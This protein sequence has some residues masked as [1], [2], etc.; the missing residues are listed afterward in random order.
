[1]H[2]EPVCERG[3]TLLAFQ[4]VPARQVRFEGLQLANE[5]QHLFAGRG[6]PLGFEEFAPHIYRGRVREDANGAHGRQRPSLP[7]R[8]S[9]PQRGLRFLVRPRTLTAEDAVLL[10]RRLPSGRCPCVVV[11]DNVSIHVA[12]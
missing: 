8:P 12:R 11:L 2:G 10:L 5:V 6:K 9:G 4:R 1:M 7:N 3:L